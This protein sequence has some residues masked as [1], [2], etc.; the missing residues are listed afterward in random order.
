M[1]YAHNI[2]LRVFC[3]GGDDELQ[4]T[5]VMHELVDLDFEKEK[6]ELKKQKAELFDERS[7]TIMIVFLD[8][9]RHTTKFLD[10][11]FKRLSSEQKDIIKRQLESRLDEKLHFFIRLDK[12]KLLEGDY[13][14]TDSGDCFHMNIAIAAYPHTRFAARDIIMKMLDA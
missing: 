7:L 13:W 14:L 10:D 1:K 5:N 9:Q 6:I 2:E 4:L 12:P 8:K 3:K 11:L